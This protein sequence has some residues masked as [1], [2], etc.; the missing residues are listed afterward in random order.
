MTLVVIRR[1]AVILLVVLSLSFSAYNL[2][3]LVK[4]WDSQAAEK[5]E[6]SIW[7]NRLHPLKQELPPGTENVGYLA[8]W[9]IDNQQQF[10]AGTGYET[11]WDLPNEQGK[12]DQINEF[13]FTK[14]VL[15]PVIVNRGF[16]YQWIIGNFSKRKFEKWLQKMIGNY[17]IKDIGGGI[18][19]IH[20][21]QK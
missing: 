21:L 11:I 13:R 16:D 9:D 14:Y 12:S 1:A 7:E 18:Y 17:E 10:P 5:N 8:E 19:L 4:H 20:R 6:V 15:A 3:S 2:F